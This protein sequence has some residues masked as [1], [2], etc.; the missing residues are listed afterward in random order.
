M[1]I[2][3]M[4][5]DARNVD[6]SQSR[7]EPM[8]KGWYVAQVE[9]GEILPTKAGNGHYLKLTYTILD[10]QF[11]GRKVFKNYNISN[12]NKLAEEI[13]WRELSALMHTIN[14]LQIQDCRQLCN[15]PLKIR[16]KIR[17][18]QGDYDDQNEIVE[19]QNINFQPQAENQ[20]VP[21]AFAAAPYGQ[22]TQQGWPA[23]QGVAPPPTM[24]GGQVPGQQDPTMYGGH[25]A[26]APTQQGG[27][28]PPPPVVGQQASA[29]PQQGMAPAQTQA[30]TPAVPPLQ[31]GA[32]GLPDWAQQ[33]APGAA[34]QGQTPWG[35]PAQ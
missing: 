25:P 16:L 35:R 4:N 30:P 22:Q 27:W 24:Y 21:P 6:P 7:F 10:G 18:G 14:V 2:T 11:K 28:Q 32:A 1:G 19:Y 17:A 20:G 15:Q 34:P 3:A 23:Q 31:H 12:Q 9:E 13:A 26:Q 33:Q 8:P 5:F 29:P